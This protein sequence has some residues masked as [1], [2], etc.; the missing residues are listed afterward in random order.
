MEP[1]PRGTARPVCSNARKTPFSKRQAPF[2]A[3]RN[4]YRGFGTF[5]WT[6]GRAPI[7]TVTNRVRLIREF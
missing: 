6:D 5:F 4:E 3:S 1:G 7:P 2:C